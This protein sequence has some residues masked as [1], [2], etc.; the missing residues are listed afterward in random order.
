[1]S[2]KKTAEQ[3]VRETGNITT[4]GEFLDC[5]TNMVDQFGR[6]EK[7]VISIPYRNGIGI[8]YENIKN[9]TSHE[10]LIDIHT[11]VPEADDIKT[12]NHKY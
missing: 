10:G 12:P 1:M 11:T 8:H 5:L 9:I 6:K 4:A 2:D 3:I 7:I